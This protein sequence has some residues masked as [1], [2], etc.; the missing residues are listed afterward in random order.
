MSK[1]ARGDGI[2]EFRQIAQGLLDKAAG[3]AAGQAFFEAGE[4]AGI[5]AFEARPAI[6]QDFAPGGIAFLRQALEMLYELM[7]LK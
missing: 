3:F 6:V 7:D 5:A 4:F 2:R 1:I